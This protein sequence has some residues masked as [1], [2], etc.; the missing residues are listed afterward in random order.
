VD[1]DW[2]LSS[3]SAPNPMFTGL[4]ENTYM[5]TLTVTDDTSPTP[6]EEADSAFVHVVFPDDREIVNQNLTGTQTLG[7][8]VQL[9]ADMGTTIVSGAVITL[10]SPLV[11]LGPDFFVE[12]GATL[13]IVNDVP[14]ECSP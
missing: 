12:E 14:P 13:I 1:I 8:C 5:T 3:T 4:V 11:I 10:F 7:A 6:L 2:S 9:T